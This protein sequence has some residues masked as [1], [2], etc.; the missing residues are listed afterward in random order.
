MPSAKLTAGQ[1]FPK[2]TVASL[3]GGE[4][5]IG[6]P[7][8]GFDWC[9]VVVYCGKHCPICTNYLVRLN[10]ILPKLRVIGIDTVAVS[11]DSRQKAQAHIQTVSP[12]FEVGYDLSIK[13]MEALG[14]YISNPRSAGETDRPFSEPGLFV[15]NDKGNLQVI[16]IS[17]AP[18]AR[19]DLE[20][21]VMGLNLIRNPENNYLARGT[22]PSKP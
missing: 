5:E 21:L 12:D 14:L 15:I 17:N 2:I 9:L 7:S 10:E 6:K 19:P 8:S 4:I 16:D 1:P 3:S 18:F 20:S 11:A 13:Q 22:Y